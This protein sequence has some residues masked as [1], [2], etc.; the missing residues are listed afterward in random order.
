MF[1]DVFRCLSETFSDVSGCF[2]TFSGV[3]NVA[4]SKRRYG[5]GKFGLT[6]S[7]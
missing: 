4:F 2:Q 3:P 1:S 5:L 7:G 6:I